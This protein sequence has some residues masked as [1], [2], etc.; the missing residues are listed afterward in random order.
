M[1]PSPERMKSQ[2][3]QAEGTMISKTIVQN[4]NWVQGD[5]A[6]FVKDLVILEEDFK[7]TI[8]KWN[9]SF[10]ILVEKVKLGQLT[11]DQ[12]SLPDSPTAPTGGEDEQS[13][14]MLRVKPL[15]GSSVLA[16]VIRVRGLNYSMLFVR[17]LG[18][19]TIIKIV[20]LKVASIVTVFKLHFV[21]DE[22]M[23]N[24]SSPQ[25]AESERS[26]REK[27]KQSQPSDKQSFTSRDVQRSV[28]DAIRRL[29]GSQFID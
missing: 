12:Q 17:V 24:A 26:E 3:L 16:R 29:Y 10:S 19:S 15:E 27:H 22:E 28:L 9:G 11:Q 18:N 1:D 2:M 4:F 5:D 14:L 20:E 23:A 8:M 21:H 7:L 6:F 25:T 13:Q